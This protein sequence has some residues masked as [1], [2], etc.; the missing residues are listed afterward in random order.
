MRVLVD[1][2]ILID[3][4]CM[5]EDFYDEA[6]K[7]FVWGLKNK[8]HIL[9]T[10]ISYINAL[11]VGK[12]YGYSVES[13]KSSLYKI[14]KFSELAIID[15]DI[16]KESLLSKWNDVEDATQYYAAISNMADCILTRN[17]NDFKMSTIPVYS[18]KEFISK[19]ENEG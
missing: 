12:R 11:Y 7:V 3:F 16:V 15:N 8:I 14:A 6:E 2:N 13:L 1:T 17:T 18:P 5:R 10:D 19:I 9:I 4:L